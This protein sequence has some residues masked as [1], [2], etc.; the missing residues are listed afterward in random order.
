MF[1]NLFRGRDDV[2]A[3]YWTNERSGKK[4]YSPAV[5]DPWN[6]AKGKSKKYLPVTDRVIHDHLVGES[7]IGCYPLLKDNTCWFLACDFDKDGWVLDS[8]AF[9]DSCNRFGVPAYLERSRSGQGGHVWMFFAASVSAVSARQLGMRLLRET[10]NVR[11]ELDLASYDRFF[12]NQI[13]SRRV[14]LET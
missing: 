4:G 13:S 10:M 3:V 7:V 2:Y 1:R 14:G 11:A 6:S 8:V 12:P 5:E 9:L